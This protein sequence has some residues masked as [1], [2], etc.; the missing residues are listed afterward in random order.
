MLGVKKWMVPVLTFF[1]SNRKSII[2]L[3]TTLNRAAYTELCYHHLWMGCENYIPGL[4]CIVI[5]FF[6]IAAMNRCDHT[7]WRNTENPR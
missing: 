3:I 7:L 4:A 2:D 5:L 1:L 6:T